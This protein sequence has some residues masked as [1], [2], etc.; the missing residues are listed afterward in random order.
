[1]SLIIFAIP[2]GLSTGGGGSCPPFNLEFNYRR[3]LMSFR[4]CFLL[5]LN[6]LRVFL[7]NTF[8]GLLL[9]HRFLALSF[10]T[11]WTRA[12]A[13]SQFNFSNLVLILLVR[14]IASL[15]DDGDRRLSTTYQKLKNFRITNVPSQLHRHETTMHCSVVDMVTFDVSLRCLGVECASHPQR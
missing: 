12:T 15:P 4:L 8:R 1:M 6:L 13:V 5:Y 11:S 7:G 2:S 3:S 9:V 14:E 10:F